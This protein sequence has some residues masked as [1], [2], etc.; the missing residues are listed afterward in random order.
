MTSTERG[1]VIQFERTAI[2]NEL[3]QDQRLAYDTRGMLIRLLCLPDDAEITAGTIIADGLAGR[4]KVYRM[5]AEAERHG[6]VVPYAKR[7]GGKHSRTFYLITDVPGTIERPVEVRTADYY[8]RQPI[9]MAVRRAV[10]ERDS[11]CCVECGTLTGLS[12]DHIVPVSS[13]GDS[14]AENLRTLCLP[15]NLKKGALVGG[16][17]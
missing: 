11:Y 12:L 1:E 9:P 16:L 3:L 4:D 13:G 6:Y 14:S 15:C 10:Y 5:L 7:M 2:S 17:Y 8:P